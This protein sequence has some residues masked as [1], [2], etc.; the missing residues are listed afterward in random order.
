MS[1][2]NSTD[3]NDR[4]FQSR[5]REVTFSAIVLGLAIGIV[6]NAAITYAGLKIGFTL[7]GSAIA[8]VLGFGVLRGLFRRGTILETNVVQTVAS[9]VN[10]SNSGIIFTVPVM[11]LLGYELD[12]RGAE[13]WLITLAGVAG[14]L[15]GTALIIPLRKQQIDIERLRFPTGTAVASILKSPGAGPKKAIVLVAGIL[16]GAVIFLPTIVGDFGYQGLSQLPGVGTAAIASG[17]IDD[18]SIDAAKL[19]GLPQQFSLVFA[20]APFAIGAGYLTGRPGL[21]VLAGGI[22]LNLVITPI[23]YSWGW[24]PDGVTAAETEQF[25]ARHFGKPLGIGMLLG[26][27]VMGILLSLPSMI[28]AIKSVVFAPKTGSREELGIKILIP[29]VAGAAV[30]LF[31]AADNAFKTPLNKTCPVSENIVEDGTYS[32]QANGYTIAF[33][34]DQA[35]QTW[36]SWSPLEQETYLDGIGAKP[37]LLSSI[38]PTLR[39]ALIA[40][41]AVMWVWLAS[42]IISQCTGLTDW[43]PI[44]GLALLTVVLVMMLA[45]VG[46]VLPAVLLGACLCVAI[47]L[48]SD[49]MQDLR[50]GYLIG[51]KPRR[52]QAVELMVVWIGPIIA[53]LTL[54][55]IVQA[56]L[57]KGDAPLGPGTDT[58]APQAQ[59]LQAVIQGVQGEELPY[60]LYGMGTLL[61]IVLGLGSFP[62]LGIL[63]GLS[64]YLPFQYISTY[65]IGCL[66]NMLV[67]RI[68]GDNWAESWGVPF[69]AGMI[70]GESLLGLLVNIIVLLSPGTA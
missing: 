31:L 57:Q 48:A 51:A 47:T 68:K 60:A 19:F 14:A 9:A 20:I 38:N 54:L 70:V 46:A 44:S 62:G 32:L 16:V 23:A 61:G 10:T 49:M 69:F 5:Y 6:L 66:I 28:E 17:F 33:D 18:T 36:Q 29:V 27:A 58:P 42:I 25:S 26:G 50:T 1:S 24:M 21:Y 8:S 7:G 52:Q 45:G 55:L 11:L 30:F 67:K 3:P 15:L 59:A 37:G 43:S 41:V 4:L 40:G 56:N 65:G 64:V 63:V 34:S 22:L 13:F 2:D 12:W 39:A 35:I 53:M